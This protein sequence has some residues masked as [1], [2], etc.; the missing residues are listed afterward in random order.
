MS[1]SGAT[2]TCD[3]CGMG[4]RDSLCSEC[5][6]VVCPACWDDDFEGC[7]GC[8]EEHEYAEGAARYEAGLLF[9]ILDGTL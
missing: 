1:G 7:R 4:A 9:D 8:R 2:A 6:S 5:L 3:R